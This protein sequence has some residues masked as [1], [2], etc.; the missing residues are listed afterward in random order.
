MKPI[1]RI[2]NVFT[3]F[4]IFIGCCALALVFTNQLTVTGEIHFDYSAWFILSVT[5]FTYACLKKLGLHQ[6][7]HYTWQNS[8]IVRNELLISGMA[9]VCFFFL[10]PQQAEVVFLFLLAVTGLVGFVEVPFTRQKFK[11][12]DLGFVKI[13]FVA[14]AWSVA[15]VIIPLSGKQVRTGLIIFLLLRSFLFVLAITMAFD[16]KD[17]EEDKQNGLDTLPL[18][19]GVS[20]TKLIAQAVLFLL[21]S[22]NTAEYLFFQIPFTNMIDINLSVLLAIVIVQL[23]EEE[24][25]DWWYYF[26]LDGLMIAQFMMVYAAKYFG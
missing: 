23:A 20:N 5:I 16:I 22:I 4:N 18:V 7:G 6:P 21:L 13:V 1:Q 17:M 26:V 25:A 10:L 14:T 19:I 2:A 24:T 9:A 12:R 15:T 8:Q 3:D 11:L